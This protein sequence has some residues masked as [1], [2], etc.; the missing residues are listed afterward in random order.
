MTRKK[1]TI[2]HEPDSTKKPRSDP[3]LEKPFNL[4]PAWQI[5]WI[6]LAGEWGWTNIDKQYFFNTIVPRIKNLETMCW[7]D[8]LSR[9][10]HEIPVAKIDRKAQKR[11]EELELDDYD[12]LVSLRFG[13]RERMWGIRVQNTLKILWW[14][15]RHEVYP[16]GKKHT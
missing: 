14:D 9:D 11:L 7:K 4:Q 5:S 13:S 15:P 16:V 10:N 2:K 1:P 8:I 12:L 6:D 3:S